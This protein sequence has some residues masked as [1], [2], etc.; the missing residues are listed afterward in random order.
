M[1]VVFSP[2][3]HDDRDEHAAITLSEI[4]QAHEDRY[5]AQYLDQ[6]NSRSLRLESW[7]LEGVGLS[8]QQAKSPLGATLSP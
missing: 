4:S 1:Y 2:D 6:S 5:S 8:N 3:M 7:L